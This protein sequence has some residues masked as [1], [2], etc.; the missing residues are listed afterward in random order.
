MGVYYV[1]VYFRIDNVSPCYVGKGKGRRWL[2]HERMPNHYNKHLASLIKKAGGELPKV[3]IRAGLTNAQACEIEV[4]LIKAIGRRDLGTGP[5]VNMTNGGD[6]KVGYVTPPE[7]REKIRQSN[8]GK[9]ASAQ[10]RARMS[11]AGNGKPKPPGH[12]AAVSAALKGKPKSD[13]HRA[14]MRAA[15]I[16]HFADDAARQKLR[17][18][19][20]GMT[21]EERAARRLKIQQ[22]TI[23]AMANPA[24]R[25]KISESRRAR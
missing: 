15:A 7:T 12:G 14:A 1:Y 16:L 3:K 18:Y 17:A 25:A 20:A 19:H 2:D 23:T 4:A 8:T 13:E 24:I 21:D 6:G 9:T 22:A 11:A 10:T 5:L